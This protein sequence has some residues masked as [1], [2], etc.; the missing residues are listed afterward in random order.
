MNNLLIDSNFSIPSEIFF[1]PCMKCSGKMYFLK[2]LD[3]TYKNCNYMCNGCGRIENCTKRGVLHCSSC[4]FDLCTKCRFC[5]KGHFLRRVYKL[6]ME[7]EPKQFRIYPKDS[8]NCDICKQNNK[9]NN[10]SF[11]CWP[12][13]Y[14]VCDKCILKSKG[15]N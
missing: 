5:P 11:K 3:I 10:G 7:G 2:K 13:G 8:F 12:C 4:F 9:N 1:F 6:N 14:D 15:R